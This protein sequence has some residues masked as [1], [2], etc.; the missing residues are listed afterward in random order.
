MDSIT[1]AWDSML[2]AEKKVVASYIAADLAGLANDIEPEGVGEV[3]QAERVATTVRRVSDWIDIPGAFSREIQE[4]RLGPFHDPGNV[5]K[6]ITK[7]LLQLRSDGMPFF[8]WLGAA[9]VDQSAYKASL[10]SLLVLR[11]DV[12]HQLRQNAQPTIEELRQHQRRLALLVWCIDRY[13][14]DAPTT[15]LSPWSRSSP[16]ASTSSD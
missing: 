10:E 12:A 5:V 11:G 7:L 15:V 6:A 8:D 9:G 2:P 16:L 14:A 13:I 3:K 4:V 1:V